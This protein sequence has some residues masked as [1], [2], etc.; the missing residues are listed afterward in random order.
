MTEKLKNQSK[1][2]EEKHLPETAVV[3]RLVNMAPTGD[4][5]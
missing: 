2:E 5:G 1:L 3:P 4:G